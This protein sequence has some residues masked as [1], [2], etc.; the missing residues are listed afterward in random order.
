MAKAILKYI[1]TYIYIWG[2]RS[3]DKPGRGG[4]L[5]K[6]DSGNC[7][8]QKKAKSELPEVCYTLA[9]PGLKVFKWWGGAESQV[10]QYGLRISGVTKRMEVTEGGRV[11]S[12]R[13]G[14]LL[15]TVS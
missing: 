14:K 12:I 1:Y 11:P 3:E 5:L 4:S 6:E 8:M 13:A 7:Y 9:I 10:G 2:G 15:K